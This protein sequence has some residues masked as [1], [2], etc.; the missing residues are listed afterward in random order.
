MANSVPSTKTNTTTNATASALND[1]EATVDDEAT[2]TKPSGTVVE[3]EATATKPSGTVTDKNTKDDDDSVM[4]PM[5]K[6]LANHPSWKANMNSADH[7]DL[8]SMSGLSSFKT[9]GNIGHGTA[10]SNPAHHSPTRPRSKVGTQNNPSKIYNSAQGTGPLSQT[11][12]SHNTVSYKTGSNWGS[13]PTGPHGFLAPQAPIEG[14]YQPVPEAP[15]PRSHA[16]VVRSVDG[17]EYDRGLSDDFDD[18]EGEE[19][20]DNDEYS[21]DLFSDGETDDELDRL[22]SSIKKLKR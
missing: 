14:G 6:W 10:G 9:Q 5:Q 19:E 18:E 7:V 17:E 15:S 22:D 8:K 21:D 20:D 16:T 11:S 4:T 13:Q 2:A 3:D 1:D 12:Q